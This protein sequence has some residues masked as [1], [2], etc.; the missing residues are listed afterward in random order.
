ME[1]VSDSLIFPCDNFLTVQFISDEDFPIFPIDARIMQS[2]RERVRLARDIESLDLQVRRENDNRNW[3][4][5]AAD[6]IG[7]LD[8]SE[9]S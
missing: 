6:D 1:E 3:K 2:V 4:K 5:K 8:D 9:D 7:I